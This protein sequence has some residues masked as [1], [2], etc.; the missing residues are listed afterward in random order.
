MPMSLDITSVEEVDK[1]KK[2]AETPKRVFDKNHSNLERP[3]FYYLVKIYKK[4]S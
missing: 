3:F 2:L 4:L 1:I